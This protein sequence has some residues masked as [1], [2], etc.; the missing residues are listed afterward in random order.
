[1]PQTWVIRQAW[2]DS[3]KVYGYRK[4]FDDLRNHGERISESRIATGVYSWDHRTDRVPTAP[5]PLRREAGRC[6]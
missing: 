5:W 3:G 1:M 2:A 6:G 4:L